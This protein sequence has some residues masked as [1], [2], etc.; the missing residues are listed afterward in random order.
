M[1]Y[2]GFQLKLCVLKGALLG[3]PFL[4]TQIHNQ[5]KV[6]TVLQLDYSEVMLAADSSK[7]S[8]GMQ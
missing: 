1:S 2:C 3:M 6:N 7:T 5:V 4:D 8:F